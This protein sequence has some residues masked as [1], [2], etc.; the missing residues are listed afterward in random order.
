VEIPPIYEYTFV[1]PNQLTQNGE[2]VTDPEIRQ[3]VEREFVNMA[4]QIELLRA[5]GQDIPEKLI[6]TFADYGPT[7]TRTLLVR[8]RVY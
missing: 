1:E 7:E 4:Y 5:R 3:R 8:R 6:T 2:A